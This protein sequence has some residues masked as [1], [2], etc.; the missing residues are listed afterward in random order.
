MFS[1]LEIINI[2]LFVGLLLVNAPTGVLTV[3]LLCII[4]AKLSQ[5]HLDKSD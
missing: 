1:I 3:V 2:I 5:I 4:W